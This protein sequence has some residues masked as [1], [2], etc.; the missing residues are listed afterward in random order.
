MSGRAVTTV[1]LWDID[2]TLLTT[3]RAG[4]FALEAALLELHG[5]EPDLQGLPTGGLTDAQVAALCLESIGA[6]ATDAAVDTFLRSYESHL[7]ECLHRRHGHVLAG[8]REIL[9]D[10]ATDP[11]VAS[12]LLTGNTPAGARA[13]LA[14]YGLWEFFG[15]GGFFCSGLG[16]RAEIARR[17]AARAHELLA[18]DAA[19]R[20]YVIG[21]TPHDVECGKAIEARTVA[22]ASGP[23]SIDE[24][25][26]TDPWLVLPALPPP[27]AL[28][29]LL[30]IDGTE[31]PTTAG[32]RR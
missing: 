9:D 1:L 32:A 22:I 8:V 13:K 24:L 29:K 7:P 30:G 19:A 12:L 10:L 20:I 28:R 23:Y 6:E 25:A 4:V 26:N 27:R 15:E 16:E 5:R 3:A 31:L 2:G 18:G 17:A 14:H 11:G 21:D